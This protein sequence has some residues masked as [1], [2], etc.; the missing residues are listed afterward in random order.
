MSPGTLTT[1]DSLLLHPLFSDVEIA[2]V[3]R[4]L[5][6]IFENMASR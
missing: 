4:V 6:K 2:T 5:Y 1:A 3:Y